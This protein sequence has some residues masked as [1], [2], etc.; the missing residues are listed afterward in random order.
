MVPAIEIKL[1]VRRTT[2]ASDC[3]LV[4]REMIIAPFAN[5]NSSRERSAYDRG[6]HG[7]AI[8]ATATALIG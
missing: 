6:P 5:G 2:E 1:T 4:C 8:E 7:G 3:A